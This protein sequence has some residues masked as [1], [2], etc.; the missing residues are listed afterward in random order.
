MYY[1]CLCFSSSRYYINSLNFLRFLCCINPQII[2]M[3]L[4]INLGELSSVSLISIPS[5]LSIIQ[6][7]LKSWSFSDLYFQLKRIRK[8]Y[9]RR[10]AKNDLV[11]LGS[12]VTACWEMNLLFK[13]IK[14]WKTKQ[15]LYWNGNILKEKCLRWM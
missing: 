8:K 4:S 6:Q 7:S 10:K 9:K 2:A 5:R 3:Q 14:L 12:K 13:S 15:I 11:K 1:G